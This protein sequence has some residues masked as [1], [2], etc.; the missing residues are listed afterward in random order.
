MVLQLIKR[1]LYVGYRILC[2]ERESFR[3]SK[4]SS[5][6]QALQRNVL[7]RKMWPFIWA[8]LREGSTQ[9]FFREEDMENSD[10]T[11]FV[12]IIDNGKTLGLRVCNDVKYADV[13][14]G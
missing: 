14:S 3:V 6:V 13:V 8:S 10:E 9:V 7:S 1:L 5:C 2:L 11:Q 4:Q 12:F